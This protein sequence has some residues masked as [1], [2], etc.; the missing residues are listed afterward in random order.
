MV[1]NFKNISAVI[2]R[3]QKR[4]NNGK[5]DLSNIEKQLARIEKGRQKVMNLY[6]MGLI[7]DDEVQEQLKPLNHHRQRFQIHI[8]ELKASEGAWGISK[9]E[10]KAIIDNLSKEVDRADPKIKKRVFQTLFREVRI[11]PK[12]GRPWKRILEIKGVYLP[13][14]GVF[15]ASPRG[16][17]PLL[18]A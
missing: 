15:V 6:Q 3:I 17:E 2:D 12:E 4:F 18:P 14:T 8:E 16:F 1:L 7:E 11:F 9:P 5:P 13:L 10:V